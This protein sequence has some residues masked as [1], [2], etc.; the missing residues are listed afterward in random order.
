MSITNET[1]VK[2]AAVTLEE[3]IKHQD[4]VEFVVDAVQNK[5]VESERIRQLIEAEMIRISDEQ[6]KAELK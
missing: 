2:I 5:K 3:I 6:M 4:L 1:I